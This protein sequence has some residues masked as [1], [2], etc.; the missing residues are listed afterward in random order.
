MNGFDWIRPFAGFGFIPI[1]S[2]HAGTIGRDSRYSISELTKTE[3]YVD[4]LS[5]KGDVLL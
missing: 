4:V 1:S 2:S 3:I 5:Q